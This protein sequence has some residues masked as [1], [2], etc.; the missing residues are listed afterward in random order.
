MIY[1]VT[2]SLNCSIIVSPKP[3]TSNT[4][5]QC[6][7]MYDL[8]NIH[9]ASHLANF[10]SLSCSFL[11]N[12]TSDANRGVQ[13]FALHLAFNLIVSCF[14]IACQILLPTNLLLVLKSLAVERKA[15]V[16]FN[17]LPKKHNFMGNRLGRGV[18]V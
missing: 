5:L 9:F 4:I 6:G 18:W 1:P 8:N 12:M 17:L 15:T 14:Y 7:D 2:R 11:L 10:L 16:L 13:Y 3:R